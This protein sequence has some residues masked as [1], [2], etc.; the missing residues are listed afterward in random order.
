MKIGIVGLGNM[1]LGMGVTLHRKHHQ[2]SGFDLSAAARSAAAA[3]GLNVQADLASL[4][5][6]SDVIILSLPK[7]QHVEAVCLGGGGIQALG[8]AGQIVIDTTTSTAAVSQA[9]HQVLAGQGIT[10]IDAPVS[11]GPSGAASGSMT[12]VVGA[13]DVDYQRIL[14]LL[15]DMSAVQVHVG[16]CGAGNI[17][18]IGNNL[19]AAAHLITTAEAVSM[20]AKAGVAPEKFL[21]G[22][23]KGS[24]RSAVSEVSFPKWVLN[25]AFDSGFTMGLMR[26]DVGLAQDL[27]QA[28][29][30]ALPLSDL[31]GQLWQQSVATLADQE[32][33]NAIVQDTDPLLFVKATS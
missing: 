8:H 30:Q 26:K 19:L 3:A 6:G 9:V 13:S 33:F 27:I 10:F 4:L 1:G 24:G 20:A 28:Q 16:E 23:N 22:I 21:A 29:A 25:Q 32:D 7:A 2:V 31:V 11:G 15:A 12:M 17:V 18:K 5:A 14:P